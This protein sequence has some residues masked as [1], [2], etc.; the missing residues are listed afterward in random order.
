MTAPDLTAPAPGVYEIDA[1]RGPSR[2]RVIV[3]RVS[4]WPTVRRPVGWIAA[5]YYLVGYAPPVQEADI[6]VEVRVY[7]VAQGTFPRTSSR[8]ARRGRLRK[9]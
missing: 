8:E 1:E 3:R 7:Y 5:L 4:V 6:T 9:H 2:A